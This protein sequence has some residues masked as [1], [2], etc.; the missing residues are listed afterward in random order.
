MG[1][2]RRHIVGEEPPPHTDYLLSVHK[3][4]AVHLYT[5]YCVSSF[6]ID[7]RSPYI[8]QF[9]ISSASDSF[10]F[11]CVILQGSFKLVS[12]KMLPDGRLGVRCISQLSPNDIAH[13]S[14]NRLLLLTQVLLVAVRSLSVQVFMHFQNLHGMY[15]SFRLLHY[16]DI[17]SRGSG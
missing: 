15:N 2:Y 1:L 17:S 10:S 12:G 5:M 16:R 8:Q 4:S 7:L 14:Y 11:Q 6:W 13:F 3:S 9:L